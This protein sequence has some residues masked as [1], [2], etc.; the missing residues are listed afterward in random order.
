MRD[1]KAARGS[2]SYARAKQGSHRTDSIVADKDAAML[3]AGLLL[4]LCF[5]SMF[6]WAAVMW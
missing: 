6:V 1:K 5:G 4:A 2:C 3:A